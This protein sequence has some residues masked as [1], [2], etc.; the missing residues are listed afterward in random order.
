[1]AEINKFETPVDSHIAVVK[2]RVWR[3]VFDSKEK[4]QEAAQTELEKKMGIL[5]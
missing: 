2:E 1:V 5:I 3:N 4:A